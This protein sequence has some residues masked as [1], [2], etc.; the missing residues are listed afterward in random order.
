MLKVGDRIAL[1][2]EGFKSKYDLE[3]YNAWDGQTLTIESV[4]E[5]SDYPYRTKEYVKGN[6]TW[7]K[8]ECVLHHEENEL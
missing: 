3:Y 4:D 5:N 1:N 8:T 2:K 7:R 6:R